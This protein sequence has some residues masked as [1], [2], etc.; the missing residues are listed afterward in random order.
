MHEMDGGGGPM[1]DASGGIPEH[2]GGPGG[3]R[4]AGKP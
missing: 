2:D 1:E 3:P 4:E